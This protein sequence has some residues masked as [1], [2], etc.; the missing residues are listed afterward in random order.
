MAE[1]LSPSDIKTFKRDGYLIKRSLL[2]PE[3]TERCRDLLW[4]EETA[5]FPPRFQRDDRS[6]YAGPYLE[7]E[8]GAGGH[9]STARRDILSD[10]AAFVDLLPQNPKVKAILEQMLGEGEVEHQ[11]GETGGVVSTLPMGGP[12][13]LEKTKNWGHVDS[14][15]D[16]RDRL[17]CAAY[18]DDVEPGGVSTASASDCRCRCHWLCR[19]RLCLYLT[20]RRLTALALW[21]FHVGCVHGMAGQPSQVSRLSHHLQGLPSER[22]RQTKRRAS[23]PVWG[24]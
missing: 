15:L 24:A 3:L 8:P 14:S 12:R 22:L 16:S 9:R 23:E 7:G 19:G 20:C 1:L 10:H 21:I 4:D 2:A 18:I 6:T 13:P 17:S 5:Y 11:H